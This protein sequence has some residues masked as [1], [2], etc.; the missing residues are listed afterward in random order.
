MSA[1]LKAPRIRRFVGVAGSSF[2][3]VFSFFPAIAAEIFLQQIDHGP[4]MTAL[5]LHLPGTGSACHREMGA[6]FP[7]KRCCSTEAGSVSPWITIR[8]RNM[9]AV[10]AGH[11]LPYRLTLV[12]AE[13]NCPALFFWCASRYAPSILRH[14][15]ITEFGP[16]FGIDSDCRSQVN[17]A[18]LECQP[19]PCSSTTRYT[20]GYQASSARLQ[21]LVRLPGLRYLESMMCSQPQ[22]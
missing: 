2:E 16:S 7:R 18:I 17:L 11:L 12:L 10:F 5:P 19:G 21:P 6:V 4:E 22:T 13:P 3:Q 20:F 14:L 15:H 9:D 8:R 1:S